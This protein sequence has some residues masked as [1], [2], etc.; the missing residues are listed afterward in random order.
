MTF[1]GQQLVQ[2]AGNR[3]EEGGEDYPVVVTMMLESD[4]IRVNDAPATFNSNRKYLHSSKS[5]IT[6]F[7]AWFLV[8]IPM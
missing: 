5:Q 4:R 8:I 6:H 1:E 2:S 7:L 3:L